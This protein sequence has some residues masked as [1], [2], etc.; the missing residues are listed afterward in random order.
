[1]M[2]KQK[3]VNM[4]H[5]YIIL[6]SSNLFFRARHLM[7]GAD[8]DSKIGLGFHIIFNSIKKVWQNNHGTHV[9]FA[10]EG[11]SWRKD[12]YLPYKRNRAETK[13]KFTE[14]Q[15]EEEQVFWEAYDTFCTFIQDKTN[16]T[17]LQHPF[18]EADD[19]MAGWVQ[20][21]PNDKHII[22]STDS[23]MH[24]LISNNVSQY[25]GVEEHLITPDGY[26]NDL[27]KAINDKKTGLP[28]KI[29]TSDWLV[30]EKSIR[31]DATDN[32]FSAYPRVRKTVL[33]EAYLDR[34]KKGFKWNNL[35][36]QKWLDHDGIEHQ[37]R[38]DYERNKIL[39]DLES[40][41]DDIKVNIFTCIKEAIDRKKDIPQ[42]G[43]HLL[44]FCGK[45]NLQKMSDQITYYSPFLTAKYEQV[46]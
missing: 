7:K 34:D 28:K 1:M 29:P 16:C 41:P 20:A 24:Q 31:G 21:H 14:S 39:I 45:W 9:V 17:T 42:V 6:D 25:N 38:E 5:T 27:G 23:D 32:I 30:F 18:L 22:V 37:V 4:T 15:K 46:Q 8:L 12:Y 3:L 2:G 40:Q 10:F 35:M 33:E 36:L 26:F 11:R 19:L 43:S 13:A 44:K